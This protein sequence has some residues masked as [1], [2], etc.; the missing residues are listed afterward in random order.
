MVKP[1]VCVVCEK[2]VIAQ[3]SVPSLI[4][5]FSKMTIN[6]PPDAPDIPRNAVAPKEWAVFSSWDVEPGDERREYILCTHI[7]FPDDTPFGEVNKLRMHIEVGKRSQIIS[8]MLAMPIGQVGFY[9]VNTWIEE[10]Q[11]VVFGPI[12]LKIELE[13]VRGLH[14]VQ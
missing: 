3:D 6:A 1:Y 13:I 11:R 4:N 5:L 2:V 14:N 10:N 7:L 12:A 9:T 8:Q